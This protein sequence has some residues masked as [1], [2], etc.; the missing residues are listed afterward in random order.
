MASLLANLEFSISEG[1]AVPYIYRSRLSIS[2]SLTYLA[3]IVD[4]QGQEGSGDNSTVL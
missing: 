1:R 3:V 2:S 4:S